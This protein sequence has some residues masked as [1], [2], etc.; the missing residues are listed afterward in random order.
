MG[1]KVMISILSFAITLALAVAVFD[2]VSMTVHTYGVRLGLRASG[3]FA[4][5][6]FV[7]YEALRKRLS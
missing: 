2:I 7:C 1:D 6:I 4:I 3:G 5:F